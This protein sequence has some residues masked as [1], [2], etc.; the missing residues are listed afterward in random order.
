MNDLGEVGRKGFISLTLRWL[1]QED[2]HNLEA[3]MVAIVHTSQSYLV[4]P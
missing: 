2:H 4:K 3:S 1:R